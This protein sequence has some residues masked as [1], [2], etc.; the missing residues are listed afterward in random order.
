MEQEGK[1]FVCE[2]CGKEVS[3]LKEGKN[4]S[5][6]FCCGEEMQLKE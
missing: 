4:P 5:A 2:K 3:V 1:K 6:P